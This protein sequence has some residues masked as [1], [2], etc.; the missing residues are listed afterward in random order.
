MESRG[1]TIQSALFIIVDHHKANIIGQKIPSKIGITLVQDIPKF[2]Q[3]FNIY[4]K[5]SDKVIHM[6]KRWVKN[7]F[8]QL[9]VGIGKSK[10][11]TMRTQFMKN[12]NPIQQKGRRVP[13]HL[14]ER[15]EKELNKLMDQKP[16]IK[17]ANC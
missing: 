9:R 12:V 3:I 6:I 7:S 1:W 11:H 14:Q 4:E 16:F 5:K 13:I 8:Q 17:L 2:N 10:N 15:V